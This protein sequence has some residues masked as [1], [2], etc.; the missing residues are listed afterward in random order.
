MISSHKRPRET[1]TAS[2]ARRSGTRLQGFCTLEN[3]EQP[4]GRSEKSKPD[5]SAKQVSIQSIQL[6][7][8][9]RNLP[10]LQGKAIS[11]TGGG[12]MS[13]VAA[14]LSVEG[15]RLRALGRPVK[16]PGA[17]SVGVS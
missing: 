15:S 10:F 2:T 6:I 1:Q 17:T 14:L 4:G 8:S 5:P 9:S 16:Y 7:G 13:D 3:T 12:D 11:K